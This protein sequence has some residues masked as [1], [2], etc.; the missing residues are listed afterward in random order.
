MTE[1]RRGDPSGF[2]RLHCGPVGVDPDHQPDRIELCHDPA[3]DES[4][5]RGLFPGESSDAGV[6]GGHVGGKTIPANERM[7]G[8]TILPK[9]LGGTILEDGVERKPENKDKSKTDAECA[10]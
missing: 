10:A 9:L 3:P 2:L 4:G 1:E 8:H 7:K 5:E 6:P